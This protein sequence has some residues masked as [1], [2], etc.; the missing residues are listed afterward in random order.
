LLS[1]AVSLSR[2]LHADMVMDTRAVT[3]RRALLNKVP[4]MT[5]VFWIIKILA[6]T[7]GETAADDLN[8]QYNLGLTN[9]TYIV[10]AVFLVAL[11]FQFRARRCVS[12]LYWL[13]I[14]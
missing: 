13:S 9:L 5:V 14:V 7:I 12:A 6:T 2:A 3:G 11:A 8:T 1:R 4:E 10:T